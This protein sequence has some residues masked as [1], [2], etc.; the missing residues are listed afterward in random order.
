[1]QQGE[2]LARGDDVSA[3]DVPLGKTGKTF[4]SS[5]AKRVI[6]IV[7][8]GNAGKSSHSAGLKWIRKY[9]VASKMGTFCFEVKF[10]SRHALKMTNILFNMV[11]PRKKFPEKSEKLKD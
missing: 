8:L 1:M 4:S 5:V 7:F 3:A 10:A 9:E 11:F 6:I 2:V